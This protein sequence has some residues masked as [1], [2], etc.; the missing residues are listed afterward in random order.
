MAKLK[1]TYFDFDGGRGEPARLALRIGGIEFEDCRIPIADWPE[2]KASYR[3]QQLPELEVD[4]RWLNQSNIIT[5]YVGKM[6]GLY[7]EDDWQAAICDAVVDTVDDAMKVLVG[8][9]FMPE[10]EKQRVRE[11]L[12]KGPLPLFIAGLN[13]SLN[14]G[15]G[16]YFASGCLTVADLKVLVFVRGL[17]DGTFDYIPSGIVAEHGP[18]LVAHQTRI[19]NYL[20]ENTPQPDYA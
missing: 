4:G 6:A 9:F 11:E 13:Q 20:Q 2:V 14:E 18:A 10:D 12:V 1:L 8:T 5:R 7:P 19:E 16:A 15:G 3:Y 17:T